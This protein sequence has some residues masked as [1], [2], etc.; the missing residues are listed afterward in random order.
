MQPQQ[1]SSPSPYQQPQYSIDYL[2]QIAPQHHRP[3]P[4]W[5]RF[6]IPGLL[7]AIVLFLLMWVFSLIHGSNS[8]SLSS[9]ATQI[10]SLQPIVDKSEPTIK[11]NQLRV[12][13]STLSLYLINASRDITIALKNEGVDI[14]KLKPS[15]T[16][17]ASYAA[18]SQRLDDARLNAVFDRTYAREMS[19]QLTTLLI[20]MKEIEQNASPST[21]QFLE[22]TVTN[23]TAPQQQFASYTD[24]TN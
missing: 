23:L 14:T 10:Q 17:A 7:V 8:V 22:T 9:V 20:Q 18:L 2:N 11:D 12:T 13:N 3:T 5:Q 24:S 16:E 6:V 21:R 19:Y 1:P 15:P 4:T